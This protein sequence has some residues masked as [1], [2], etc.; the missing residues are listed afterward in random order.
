MILHS[1][2]SKGVA[3]RNWA[4]PRFGTFDFLAGTSA[5][6]MLFLLLAAGLKELQRDDARDGREGGPAIEKDGGGFAV[7]KKPKGLCNYRV[8]PVNFWLSMDMVQEGCRWQTF[9]Q[10]LSVDF[11]FPV[12]FTRGLFQEENPLLKKVCQRL[13]EGRRHRVL[14]YLDEGVAEAQPEL[15]S[16]IQSWF[17]AYEEELELVALP[18]IVP[19]GEAVKNDP[20][21]VFDVVRVAKKHKLCRHSFIIA[22]GGGAVLDMV[23]LGAALFHR[24]LRLI[25]VPTTILAQN[26]AGVGVK[27]G[28]NFNGIKNALGTFA[29]PFAVIDDFD[30]WRTLSDID[31]IGGVSEAFKVAIIK[32]AEFLKYLSENA[33]G[34]R[35][36]D[37]E[38]MEEVVRKCALLHLEHI[39]EGGDPFELGQA[40]PLDF[41]HWSAHRLETLSK[42]RIHHGQAVAAGIAIDS[43]YANLKNWLSDDELELILSGLEACG[44][45]LWNDE[46]EW[47]NEQGEREIIQGLEDFREHLG[48]ELTVTFPRGIGARQEVSEIDRELL[49]E[50]LQ[51]LA[52]R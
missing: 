14:V 23:G 51:R 45:P 50:A 18:Q 49:E 5:M 4:L 16:Q 6:A 17:S 24:G 52:S 2:I 10:K 15:V 30:F 46:F 29:P 38:P 34:L 25:R 11:E 13:K 39:R 37:E 48:G 3:E 1:K 43:V 41:G 47:R 27:N 28:I 21:L 31:W 12:I 44:F 36:R 7:V 19:G 20:E 42:H 40:R 9:E 22:I 26:D 8:T 35:E 32:D 33:D